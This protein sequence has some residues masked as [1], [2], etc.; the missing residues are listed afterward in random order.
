MKGFLVLGLSL[1]LLG[2]NITTAGARTEVRLI[3]DFDEPTPDPTGVAV[4]VGEFN[5]DFSQLQQVGL[6]DVLGNSR[7]ISLQYQSGPTSTIAQ[8]GVFPNLP[9]VLMVDNGTLSEAVVT[10]TVVR[11]DNSGA[12]L[13]DLKYSELGGGSFVIDLIGSVPITTT[14]TMIVETGTMET[15]QAS[16]TVT[17]GQVDF[18]PVNIPFKNFTQPSLLS[19]PFQSIS[20][21][22]T[23]NAG[24]NVSIDSISARGTIPEPSSTM[25]IL[26]LS[27]LGLATRLK[28]R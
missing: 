19:N 20:L 10:T 18:T 2:A 4:S 15:T 14:F 16:V 3:D 21:Q 6:S 23:G 27:A 28:K 11:W 17:G 26:T 8:S 24:N 7:Y 9:G 25:G 22:I 5:L 1:A 12:G 13:G